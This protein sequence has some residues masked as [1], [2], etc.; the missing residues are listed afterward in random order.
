VAA[1]VKLLA[2]ATAQKYLSLMKFHSPLLFSMMQLTFT[3]AIRDSTNRKSCLYSMAAMSRRLASQTHLEN[4]P[5]SKDVQSLRQDL[6]GLH[7]RL[8]LV[9]ALGHPMTGYA[10]RLQI[11]HRN[12]FAGQTVFM[13][14]RGT[15]A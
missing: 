15:I 13:V 4:L 3:I 7:A 2:R 10:A 11:S 8:S 14:V 9:A 12:D 1:R 6:L 5:A